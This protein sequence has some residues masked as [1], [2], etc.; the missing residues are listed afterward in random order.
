VE[1][2]VP[3]RQSQRRVVPAHVAKAIRFMQD[4]LSVRLSA[5]SI[6]AYCDVPERT[7]RRHFKRFTG[8]TLV[9]F[10]RNLRLAAAHR[11]LHRGDNDV[12]VTAVAADHGFSHF[13][14]FAARYRQR[15]AELPSETRRTSRARSAQVLPTR[16]RDAVT[17]NIAPFV[18]EDDPGR[19]ALAGL[20][21]DAVIRAL[22]RV[23]WL[24]VTEATKPG[25]TPARYVLRG[26]INAY[27]GN[28]QVIVRLVEAASRLQVW[29]AAFDGLVVDV[30]TLRRRAMRVSPAPFPA[31]CATPKVRGS[32]A[33]Q[34]VIERRMISLCV[35]S[36]A[37]A[38]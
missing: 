12:E 35:P 9:P 6:A 17:L 5:A 18:T 36:G 29:G 2:E 34:R 13:G 38:R 14:Q 8:Q 27:G 24:E 33:S 31:G 23:R 22:G 16:S 15:F 32:I 19:V 30:P 11:V 7:L 26:R 21:T 20:I 37:R 4:N 3:C 10:H 1:S 28:L 25:S